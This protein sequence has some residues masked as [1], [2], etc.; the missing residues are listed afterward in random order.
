MLNLCTFAYKILCYVHN[1]LIVIYSMVLN[2][3]IFVVLHNLNCKKL[4]LGSYIEK[5]TLK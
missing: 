5:I 2:N 1:H 4:S 3:V